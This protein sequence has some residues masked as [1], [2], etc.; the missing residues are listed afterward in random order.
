MAGLT[1]RVMGAQLAHHG[2]DP[3]DAIMHDIQRF[4]QATEMVSK[5]LPDLGVCLLVQQFIEKTT[6][7]IEL[8]ACILGSGRDEIGGVVDF[9]RHAGGKYSQG[10]H[11]L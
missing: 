4:M 2:F 6:E 7:P 3:P 11:F 1:F 5:R 9:M 10:R 8:G